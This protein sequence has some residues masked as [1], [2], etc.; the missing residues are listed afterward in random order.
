MRF[1]NGLHCAFLIVGSLL[2][3]SARAQANQPDGEKRP[4]GPPPEMVAA[5]NGLTAGDACT[6]T[7]K[8]QAL[9]GTCR[10]GPTSDASLA[11]FPKGPPPGRPRALFSILPIRAA[12][13]ACKGRAAGDSC[14]VTF[15][16]G[17]VDGTCGADPHQDGSLI[18]LPAN[19]QRF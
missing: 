11:C 6:V 12:V 9:S 5:C 7:L 18:C 10:A 4:G 16:D 14:S 13:E 2:A 17:T 8:G 19:A 15:S 3:G 1:A